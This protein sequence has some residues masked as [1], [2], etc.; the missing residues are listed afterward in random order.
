SAPTEPLGHDESSS[1][2]AELSL[3]DSE[4][5]SDKEVSGIDAGDQD[6]DQA[7]P[8]PGIQDEDQAG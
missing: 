7:G 4:T 1:L 2:Y 6:E 5:E 8:N 3:T